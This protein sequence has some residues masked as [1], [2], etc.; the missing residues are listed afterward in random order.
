MLPQS[1]RKQDEKFDK[2]KFKKKFA[3]SPIEQ[4]NLAELAMEN[5]DLQNIQEIYL[6][7]TA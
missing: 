1:S 3:S 2:N 6:K 4:L 7:V 5:G